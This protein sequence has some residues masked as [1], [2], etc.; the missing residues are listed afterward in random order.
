MSPWLHLALFVAN[1]ERSES[2]ITFFSL[3]FTTVVHLLYR[4]RSVVSA[5][6]YS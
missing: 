2:T 4:Y 6:C 5:V 1:A 3:C